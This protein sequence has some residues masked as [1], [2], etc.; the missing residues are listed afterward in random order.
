MASSILTFDLLCNTT[1]D[2]ITMITVD[3]GKLLGLQK[4]T[5]FQPNKLML[6]DLKNLKTGNVLVGVNK[7]EKHNTIP[8]GWTIAYDQESAKYFLTHKHISSTNGGNA[9]LY[10]MATCVCLP[11][12]E[13]ETTI[14]ILVLFLETF[15]GHSPGKR[16]NEIRL[17]AKEL[18]EECT[19]E[20]DDSGCS[21]HLLINV[22]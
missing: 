18:D 19:I 2:E 3:F 9:E 11:T 16:L 12:R 21:I 6:R 13:F 15:R 1:L 14:E 5:F 8:S 17:K 4:L 7:D 20:R 10:G 22:E